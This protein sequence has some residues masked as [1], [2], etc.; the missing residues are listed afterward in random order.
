MKAPQVQGVLLGIDVLEA[1][2]FDVLRGKRVGLLTHAAGVNRHGE[3]S[4]DIL[5][6]APEVRLVALYGVEHGLRGELPAEQTYPDSRDARTGLPLFS[7][8]SGKSRAPTPFQLAGIDVLVIDLQDIGSRSY[9]YVSAMRMALESCF[10]AGKE[11]VVLD[12]PNPLGG[13]TVDGPPLDRAWMSYVGAFPVPYVHGLTIGELA[14]MAKDTPGILQI[15]DSLRLRGRLTVVPMQGWKRSMLWPD[16]GLRWVPTS[17][18]IRDF[19]AA[20]GYA[21]TG[22]GCMIGGFSHG[23]GNQYP[24]RALSHRRASADQIVRELRALHLAG[25]AFETVT[26]ENNAGRPVTGVYVR[27]TDYRTWHPTELSIQL[28]RLSCRLSQQNP[29]QAATDSDSGNLIRHLGSERFVKDLQRQGASIN[30]AGYLTAW[31]EQNRRFQ[32]ESRRF[33]LY[34]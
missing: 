32:Q 10:T 8:Y 21:M 11:V 9:T 3:S 28:L 20:V 16:T 26:A 12:R 24:F 25:L 29:F 27:V 23:I 17:T 30:L 5:R 14:R 31:Q 18:R 2:H 4:I 22:L 33:Y 34:P 1:R 6:H 15:P 7:L 13:L 19:D